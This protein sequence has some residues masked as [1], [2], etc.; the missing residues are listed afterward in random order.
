MLLLVGNVAR[1]KAVSGG[2]GG[3]ARV[4]AAPALLADHADMATRA[5]VVTED[6]GV[7][8]LRPARL[9]DQL[10]REVARVLKAKRVHVDGGVS[11]LVE[12]NRPTVRVKA[13]GRVE[14]GVGVGE[15]EVVPLPCVPNTRS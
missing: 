10:H 9:D 13:G 8:D 7:V 4:G 11:V 6:P 12:D 15:G 14:A 2:A 5:V 3:C 1:S